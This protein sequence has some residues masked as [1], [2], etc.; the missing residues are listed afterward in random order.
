MAD[1]AVIP[2]IALMRIALAQINP[3]VGDI[4][5][6]TAKHLDFIARAKQR[7][8]TLVV[9]S[10]LSLL[11]YPPKDLLLKSQFIADSL[12]ALDQIARQVQ[13]IDVILGYADRNPAPVG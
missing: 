12:R 8:A 5:A 3:T 11:G 2:R 4:V 1:W 13:G 7:G 6:N 10:E 9:F